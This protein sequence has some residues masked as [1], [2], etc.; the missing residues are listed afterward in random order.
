ME[1]E[2]KFIQIIKHKDDKIIAA[3]DKYLH[4]S[5]IKC[6]EAYPNI[7]PNGKC[8]KSWKKRQIYV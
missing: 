3:L 5:N 2:K 4:R 6:Y 8:R 7:C 1:Q